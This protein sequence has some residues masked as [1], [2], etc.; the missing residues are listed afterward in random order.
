MR[1]RDATWI[2]TALRMARQ[3]RP[4]PSSSSSFSSSASL[5]SSFSSSS[6]ST[7][8]SVSSI[9]HSPVRWT[10]DGPPVAGPSRSRRASPDADVDADPGDSASVAARMR[11][12]MRHVAQPVAVAVT[13]SPSGP[14]GA[15]LTSLTSLSLHPV[16]LI[17]FSLRLPS[18]LAALI[19]PDPRGP[20]PPRPL[21]A[22]PLPVPLL[23]RAPAPVPRSSPGAHTY[24]R[25]TVSLLGRRCADIAESLS[26]PGTDQALVFSSRFEPW[27][28]GAATG[29]PATRPPVAAGAVGSLFVEVLSSIPLADLCSAH[30]DAGLC[31]THEHA[32]DPS[33]HRADGAGSGDGEA[34]DAPEAQEGSE[35]FVCRVLDVFRGTGEASLLHCDRRY[36]GPER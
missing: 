18:R 7:S 4:C 3:P 34:I 5:S 23:A 1:A 24:P 30:D 36:T 2:R 29:A 10:S 16:P 12:V 22:L 19:R 32:A 8:S 21:A 6:L 15:T 11:E 35:L 26:R 17:A 13:I 14:H 25:L 33:S 20:P 28:A 9:S 31:D 27:D